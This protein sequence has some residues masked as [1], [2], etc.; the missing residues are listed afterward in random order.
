MHTGIWKREANSIRSGTRVP[1]CGGSVHR[2]SVQAFCLAALL[3]GLS[4]N[5]TAQAGA[6]SNITLYPLTTATGSPIGIAAG[7]DGALWF[8]EYSGGASG[9]QIGRITTAGVVT[10]YPIANRC[11][12]VGIAA[13]PDGALWFTCQ[14]GGE[15]GRITTA[16]VITEHSVPTANSEPE[17]ITAGPDGA[18]WFTEFSGNKIGRITTAG[19][20]TEFPVPTAGSGLTYITVGPDRALWF[21]EYDGN[22]IGRITTAGVITEYPIPG[23][24][25]GPFGIAA[26]PDG[27][28]WF[29]EA[30]SATQI[31]RITT[32]GA[33]TGYTVPGLNNGMLGIAAGPDG[34]LWFV[35]G[36]GDVSRVTATG[37]FTEYPIPHADLFPQGIAAGP[38][39]ALWFT[40]SRHIGRAPACGL[41]FSASFANSTLTMN[42]DLGID[43]PATFSIGLRNAAGPIGTPFS[44][45][46]PATVPPRA[47]TMNWS[48]FPNLG[49]VTVVP[50]LA[51]AAGQSL[52]AEWTTVDTA[53]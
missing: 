52:C 27:A 51:T 49:A 7:P 31:G 18:L 11:G 46:I 32:A 26:G 44:R 34:A 40:E 13:G 45:A 30:S 15:I 24:N 21:T 47:F 38:D 5:A 48:H 42:F 6:S 14:N 33:L 50:H 12:A 17:Y 16:G 2:R 28:L 37:V 1:A 41:G 43:I 25:I 4:A 3:L 36:S 35:E 19:A 22:K 9:D 39:G 23:A 29:T 8:A 10:Q 20:F 53:Q